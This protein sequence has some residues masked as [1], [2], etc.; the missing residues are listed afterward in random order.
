MSVQP[1]SLPHLQSPGP[2]TTLQ[3]IGD[4][5][6]VDID[7]EGDVLQLV[8]DGISI[9]SFR[10]FNKRFDFAPTLIAPA[11]SIRRRLSEKKPFSGRESERLVRLARVSAQAIELLGEDGAQRWLARPMA[12]SATVESLTPFQL[13]A[14]SD[15]GA[16]LVENRILKT[17]YGVY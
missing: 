8:R 9:K 16:R 17:Q 2:A 7:S 15:A 4:L 11:T 1:Q 5:L 14:E 6:G 3:T 13:A 10:R 12:W